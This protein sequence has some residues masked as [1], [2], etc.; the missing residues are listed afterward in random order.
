MALTCGIG[1]STNAETVA[2]INQNTS[3]IATKITKVSGGT[4]D[5]VTTLTADG[6]VQDSGASIAEIRDTDT[7]TDGLINGVYTL[8]ERA[9]LATLTPV[10]E[11][12]R[13]IISQDFVFTAAGGETSL[14]GADDNGYVLD[15]N[16]HDMAGYK[17]GA[18]LHTSDDIQ[19]VND[20]KVDLTVAL[21]AGEKVII[22][23]SDYQQPSDFKI[24]YS[25]AALKVLDSSAYIKDFARPYNHAIANASNF[26]NLTGT[27]KVPYDILHELG[28][29]L[30]STIGASGANVTVTP[31]T[32]GFNI[33]GG[34]GV[35]SAESV[36]FDHTSTATGK[37]MVIGFDCFITTDGAI[38]DSYYDGSDYVSNPKGSFTI[39]N[40]YN[41]II[42][43]TRDIATT[44]T[45]ISKISP[46]QVSYDIDITNITVK[47]I[48]LQTAS[49]F[50][51]FD[52][53]T[54]SIVQLSADGDVGATLPVSTH[55]SQED[56]HQFSFNHTTPLSAADIAAIKADP[57][58][59]FRML[60]GEVLPS[61][62]SNTDVGN[63]WGGNEGLASGAF[64]QDLSVDLGATI[65]DGNAP[66]YTAGDE[67]ATF[68][69][70]TDN[71][72]DLAVTVAGT[73]TTRPRV[74]TGA[75]PASASKLY[76]FTI[77]IIL[78]SGSGVIQAI[79][80]AGTFVAG[81]S[82][83]PSSVLA[84]GT[85]TYIGY[86][87][88]GSTIN[89]VQFNGTSI[90]DISVTK[91]EV[92]EATAAEIKDYDSTCRTTLAN[93]S[94]GASNIK[95]LQ[96][97]SGR[98]TGIA[99]TNTT[100]WKADGRTAVTNWTI[101]APFTITED[102]DGDTYDFTSDGNRYK[103]AVADGTYTAPVGVWVLDEFGFDG[104]TPVSS[105][106]ATR[107]VKDIVIP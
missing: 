23:T 73:N 91:W 34:G 107:L 52:H 1:G 65:L 102:I 48:T 68:T 10:S 54:K 12:V 80:N 57:N 16:I 49:Y 106:G 36:G 78:N 63:F 6:Q 44:R 99:A 58:L 79:N 39:V 40:G 46:A 105:R 86:G 90:F 59:A 71:S 20:G 100:Q 3:D 103:N 51:Y 30:F 76:L 67:T 98:T 38:F 21:G 45:T 27:Q 70:N 66:T 87:T 97:G 28:S 60:K 43:P 14:S 32:D 93:Q 13:K 31:I 88:E 77:D 42:V 18:K 47:E 96:D 61:G 19:T 85:Y 17:D 84:T 72:F 50:S 89:R 101:A 83:H 25:M 11:D 26:I 15:L 81:L 62:F 69:G 8:A 74:G 24:E 64:I 5:N 82:L 55:Y 92:R 37:V 4:E 22:H 41:E 7:H 53:A 95:L 35:G 94:T 56:S 2:Q 29:D 33:V 9:K 75:T 104:V